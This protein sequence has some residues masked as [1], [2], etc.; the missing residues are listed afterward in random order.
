MAVFDYKEVG[1]NVSA[2]LF[3]DAL[4]I[5]LYSYHNLDNGFAV[6]YQK[7]GMGTGLPATLVKAVLGGVDSQG[8]VPGIP[9]NPDS[10]KLAREAVEKAGWSP[11]SA[12]QLGY[13]GKVDQ[14][15][16]FFGEKPG[17]ESA[18][19]EILGK[20]NPDGQLTAIGIGVR[21]TSGPRESL[22]TDSI[23]DA[24]SALLAAIGPADYAKN[25]TGNAFV[26][27]AIIVSAVAM[28]V[29]ARAWTRVGGQVTG[30]R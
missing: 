10:E 18:Q 11:I 16:T 6:G 4:A 3:K 2:A 25:Y 12:Q 22:I 5:T 20:Y 29:I 8:V 13:A 24:I 17:Y 30:T 9:W 28:I 14:R 7:N 15:G 19:V 26:G 27:G 21:G 1:S 23:G